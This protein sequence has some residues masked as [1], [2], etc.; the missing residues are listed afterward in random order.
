METNA[1][2]RS[3][4]SQYTCAPIAELP[5]DTSSVAYPKEAG[6]DSMTVVRPDGNIVIA[7]SVK[8]P[9]MYHLKSSA[10]PH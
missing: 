5:S 4:F 2:N 9:Q 10:F 3:Q 1:F 6:F 7:L 8:L